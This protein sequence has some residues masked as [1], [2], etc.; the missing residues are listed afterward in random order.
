MHNC[1]NIKIKVHPPIV[2][3]FLR[4]TTTY[5]C[6]FVKMLTCYTHTHTHTHTYIYVY[7]F[8]IYNKLYFIWI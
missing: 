5:T 4:K 6:F 1:Y 2:A 7:L 8:F 3:T